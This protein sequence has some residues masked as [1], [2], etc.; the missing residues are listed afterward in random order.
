M[1]KKSPEAK[2]RYIEGNKL[3]CPICKNDKF[4]ARETLMN[5][6]G[7]TFLKLEWANKEAQNYICD[8]CGYVYWFL[9]Q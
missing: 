1:N 4:W 2:E 9:K 7:M 3:A 8:G 6:K 5:T